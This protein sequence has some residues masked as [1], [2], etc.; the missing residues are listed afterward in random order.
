M[1]MKSEKHVYLQA[2]T[3]IDPATGYIEMRIV[4]SPWSDLVS[5]QVELA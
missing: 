3:I 4:K 2:A 1:T 5:N